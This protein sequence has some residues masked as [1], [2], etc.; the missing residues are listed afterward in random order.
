[1]NEKGERQQEN[2]VVLIDFR[3]RKHAYVRR[4]ARGAVAA[5]GLHVKLHDRGLAG[6]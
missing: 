2:N 6:L 5:A 4:G 3:A 1:M